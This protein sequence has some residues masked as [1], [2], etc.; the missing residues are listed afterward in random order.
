MAKAIGSTTGCTI[1]A[2]DGRLYAFNFVVDPEAGS[3]LLQ[4]EVMCDGEFAGS[5]IWF[6]GAGGRIAA[7]MKGVR[8]SHF[9]TDGSSGNGDGIIA[10][11]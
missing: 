4:V 7:E 10:N 8:G 1:I 5:P 11:G 2:D 9:I 3:N 6:K